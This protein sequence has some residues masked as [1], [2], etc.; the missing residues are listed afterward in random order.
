MLVDLK[1]LDYFSDPNS[2]LLNLRNTLEEC[3]QKQR[4][5]SMK[6]IREKISMKDPASRLSGRNLNEGASSMS[7]KGAGGGGTGKHN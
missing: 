3:S 7:I 4:Q 2:V 1:K 6:K 5:D